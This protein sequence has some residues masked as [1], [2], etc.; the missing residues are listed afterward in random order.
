[1]ALYNVAEYGD[2]DGVPYETDEVEVGDL[3]GDA[4]RLQ[5]SAEPF[6]STAISYSEIA[7][8]WL[9]P[10]GDYTDLRVVRSNDGFP[11][12][13]ED[14]AVVY[15]WNNRDTDVLRTDFIDG[16]ESDKPLVPGKF[17]YYRVWIKL[18]DNRWR[19]AADTYT[20]L[21]I[22]HSTLAPDGTEL[23][24][25]KNKLLDVLPRVYT[26]ASQSP[27]DEVDPNSDLARF[28][29]GPSFELDRILTYAELLLPLESSRFVSPEILML[30]SMQLGLPL[31]PFLATKQQRRLAREALYIYQNK[32]TIKSVGA[33]VESLTGFAPEVTNSPNL[34]LTIQD[35]SFTGGTGFWKPVGDLTIELDTT[36]P[37]VGP[38]VEPYVDDYRYVAKITA[39][40]VGSRIVSGTDSPVKQ[41]TPVEPGKAYVFSGYGRTESETMGVTGYALWYDI[42]G[43]LIDIDPPRTFV[44]TPQLVSDEW[45]RFEFIGRTPG[46]VQAITALSID[47]GLLTFRLNSPNIMVR[48]ETVIV[49]GVSEFIDG[50]YQIESVGSPLDDTFNQLSVV[51]A[52]PDAPLTSAGGTVS[53]AIPLTTPTSAELA[54]QVPAG[55][56]DPK[57]AVVSASITDGIATVTFGGVNSD[58]AVGSLIVLQAINTIL[59]FGV[60][61]VLSKVDAGGVTTVTFQLY[62]PYTGIP[63]ED[64]SQDGAW[65]PSMVPYGFGFK[66]IPGTGFPAPK[67]YYAGFELVMQN[68]NTLYLDL[69]QMAEFNVQEFHEARSVEILLYPTKTNYLLNPGFHPDGMTRTVGGFE[70]PIWDVSASTYDNVDRTDLGVVGAG[71]SLELDPYASV[72]TTSYSITS[73]VATLNTAAAHNLVAGDMFSI[74]DVTPPISTVAPYNTLFTVISAPTS[75]SVTF[76]LPSP[77]NVTTTT[78]VGAVAPV[79]LST[80]SD[81]VRSNKFITASV[82][83][84]TATSTPEPMVMNVIA[85]DGAAEEIVQTVTKQIVLTDEWQRFESTVFV[86]RV[87][88]ESVIINMSFA[89]V[90]SGQVLYFDHAQVEDS[91]TATDYFDGD[92]PPSYGAVWGNIP[93]SF[94]PT[95]PYREAEPYQSPSHLYPNLYIKVTRL[96]QEL[97]KYIPLNSSFLIRWYGGGVAKPLL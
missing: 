31:E 74:V 56:L 25:T 95:A 88:P 19:I 28:L 41:G 35:S 44:Q 80:V 60:H 7:L 4:P 1:M 11:E 18:V 76:A 87:D 57:W 43:N 48:G 49:S 55:T 24:T 79:V 86:P 66:I 81:I 50:V 58:L 2:K 29:D 94:D 33:F 21:P 68:E 46:V 71:Y 73:N 53:E 37:G 22:R 15:S 38:E 85:Y 97:K 78:F 65:A 69:F 83:A 13:A 26:T 64:D 6:N 52:L 70:V 54:V 8:S 75:T 67:A 62:T 96:Q 91:F 3:Y 93:N 42:S 72:L 45:D 51:T 10:G 5:F 63:I 47:S 30:Q 16:T 92:L 77:V 14:G 39:N 23:V 40:E 89:G 17:A 59:S 32:G 27:I 12:T 20:L 90:M 84:K 61:T 82:Y 34:V 36:T 9:R